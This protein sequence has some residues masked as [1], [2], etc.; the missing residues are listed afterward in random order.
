M[1]SREESYKKKHLKI[2]VHSTSRASVG[3][4]VFENMEVVELQGDHTIIIIINVSGV[5]LQYMEQVIA[6]RVFTYR[7]TH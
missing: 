6:A 2:M 7:K 5:R 3:L 1:A 4:A